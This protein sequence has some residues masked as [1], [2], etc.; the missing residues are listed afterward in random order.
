MPT[1]PKASKDEAAVETT[2]EKIVGEKA[3]VESQA[4][5]PTGP[6]L[7]RWIGDYAQHFDDPASDAVPTAAP[8][9][10]VTLDIDPGLT[11]LAQEFFENGLLLDASGYTPS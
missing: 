9:D 10:F 2:G 1:T 6:T 4:T 5:A 3:D 8:G 7:Y 11:P